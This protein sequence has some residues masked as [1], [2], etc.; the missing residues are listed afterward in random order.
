MERVGRKF[1]I[2]N[3]LLEYKYTEPSLALRLNDRA[4]RRSA[5]HVYVDPRALQRLRSTPPS[6]MI[7]SMI[8]RTWIPRAMQG[9]IFV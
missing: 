2:E 4:I 3:I 9:E 8:C 1:L 7:W 6:C 5:Q